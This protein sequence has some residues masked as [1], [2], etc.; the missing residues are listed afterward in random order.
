MPLLVY[1]I[2]EMLD[3]VLDFIRHAAIGPH[4]LRSAA[5]GLHNLWNAVIG[6][7]NLGNAAIGLDDLKTRKFDSREKCP[8]CM[9]G[10]STLEDLPKA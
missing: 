10:K 5:I 9:I 3:I 8:S 6:L 4:N 2:L 1:T 7:H